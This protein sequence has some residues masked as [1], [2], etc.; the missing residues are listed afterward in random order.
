MTEALWSQLIG[1]GSALVGVLL[2]LLFQALQ[3]GNENARWYAE[4]FMKLRIDALVKL[5]GTVLE[6]QMFYY[7]YEMILLGD[8]PFNFEQLKEI[9]E[10]G[11]LLKDNYY[12]DF[13]L[14]F[15]HLTDS[16]DSPDS[17][18]DLAAKIKEAF[19]LSLDRYLLLAMDSL[20]EENSNSDAQY[21]LAER[22]ADFYKLG[23]EITALLSEINQALSPRTLQ[24]IARGR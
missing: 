11:V 15:F 17:A 20:I 4:F 13:A 14:A 2:T 1:A 21:P 16:T 10:A 19:P 18:I 8:P 5:Q 22:E 7:K 9:L 6:L 3:R 24:R 23:N 12:R